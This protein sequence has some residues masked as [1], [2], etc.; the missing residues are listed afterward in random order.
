M[1]TY[2]S[3]G[4]YL[5]PVF[6]KAEA[7]LAT[8]VPGFVGFATGPVN[9]P[10]SLHRK[11]EFLF[12]TPPAGFL[13]D[14]VTGFFDNA[15]TRCYV[16]IADTAPSKDPV[17]A[18][19]DAL[20]S[21]G[22]LTDLDLVA[23]PDAMTLADTIATE[24]V[25]K[26]ALDHCAAHGD[27]LA[28]LDGHPQATTVQA[29]AH[30]QRLGLGTQEP[31]NGALY[32][33]WIAVPSPGGTLRTIPPCGHVAGVFA[34]T[35]QEVGVFRAPANQEVFGVLDLDVPIDADVQDELNPEGINCLRP[36]RGRGIRVWGA[37]TLSRQPEWRYV[38]VRRLFLTV[39]RWID[40]HMPWAAFEPN[41]GRL[42][43]RINRELRTY[44][45]RLWQ[46]GGLAGRTEDE[47]FYV[48]CDAETN[49]PEVREAGQVITEIGLAPS[50]PAE[51]VV[52]RII[53]REA[54]VTA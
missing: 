13:A 21:L 20:A 42:W 5:E 24:Q 9:Q 4:V 7:R 35:D 39:R 29:L 47:A 3:P 51:F 17:S 18:L 33:P 28:I 36:F 19:S 46:Q 54:V 2:R 1:A 26:K 11:D 37:R 40:L 34:R 8:G 38:N 12:A 53:H 41:D 48:K 14:A 6:L 10:M 25:Q 32:Y 27:R 49:P 31:V 23:V 22:P 52:V 30:R 43:V 45:G 44:L 16:A 15:G 50:V